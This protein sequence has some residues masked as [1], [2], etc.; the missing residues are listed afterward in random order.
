[1]IELSESGFLVESGVATFSFRRLDFDSIH[2]RSIRPAPRP[3]D[4]PAYLE[5]IALRYGFDRSIRAVAY[6]TSYIQLFGAQ[7]H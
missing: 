1:M 6:P 5:R 2:F 3:L 4:Q 7:A